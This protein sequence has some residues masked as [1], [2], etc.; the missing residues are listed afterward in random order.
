MGCAGGGHQLGAVPEP[1]SAEGTFPT[2]AEIAAM[3]DLQRKTL[4]KQLQRR[5][6]WCEF[7]AETV[8]IQKDPRRFRR[9]RAC[10]LQ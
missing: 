9:D 5:A 1:V 2:A 3:N 6:A 4:E 7:L 8:G 10:E